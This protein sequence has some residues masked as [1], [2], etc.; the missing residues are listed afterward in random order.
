MEDMKSG[1]T[2]EIG[3]SGDPM[4]RQRHKF[5]VER[6]VSDSL[7]QKYQVMEEDIAFASRYYKAD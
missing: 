3:K 7:Y 4:A 6:K 2:D 1:K 5:L